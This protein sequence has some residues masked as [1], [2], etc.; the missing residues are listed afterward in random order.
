M[1]EPHTSA[2]TVTDPVCGMKVTVLFVEWLLNLFKP[3]A[4]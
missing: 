3:T 1:S 4:K 2:A